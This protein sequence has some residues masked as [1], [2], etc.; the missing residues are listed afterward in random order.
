LRIFLK[1]LIV[2]GSFGSSSLAFEDGT[3]LGRAELILG[4]ADVS[5]LLCKRAPV[6]RLFLN[7]MAHICKERF[8]KRNPGKQVEFWRLSWGTG[9]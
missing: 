1:S 8:E 6:L 2:K 7:L 3:S 5:D 4:A 9:L